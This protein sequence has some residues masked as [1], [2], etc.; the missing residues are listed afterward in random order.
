MNNL[1]K[2]Y[3]TAIIALA[4]ASL[5]MLAPSIAM[6]QKGPGSPHFVGTAKATPNPDHSVSI[7][8]K[9]AGLSAGSFVD[10]RASAS[11]VEAT[12]Q[13][14][15]PG[16]NDPPAKK[17]TIPGL[18]A[19]GTFGPAPKNGNLV[20]TIILGPPTVTVDDAKCTNGNQQGWTVNLI[21]VTYTG[22]SLTSPTAGTGQVSPSSITA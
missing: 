1:S 20:D 18:T 17:V 3:T 13:C 8:W 16:G 4:L 14:K 11:T 5:I 10:V 9:I 7:T 19:T 2:T 6:A 21:S 12:V 15:N 22:L